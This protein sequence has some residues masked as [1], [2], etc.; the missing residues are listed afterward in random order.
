[1]KYARVVNNIAVDTRATDP[2]GL[3]TPNIVAEFVQVP[4]DVQDG[5][6]L[7]NGTWAAPVAAPVVPPVPVAPI[8]PKVSPIQ[9]KLLFT[10]PERIAIAMAKQAD[11]VL[12]DLYSI[13]DDPRLTEVD[14][15]LQSTKDALMYLESKG[16]ITDARRLEILTGAVK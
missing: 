8:P 15:N 14:L 1:M 6:T 3:F 9:Y 4:D 16:F 10:A 2:T 11:P 13:L 7:A 5:W 12:Q